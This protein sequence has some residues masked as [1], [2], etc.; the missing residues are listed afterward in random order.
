VNV[1]KA[2]FG[3]GRQGNVG[4]LQKD[5]KNLVVEEGECGNVVLKVLFGGGVA[6][7]VAADVGVKVG[8]VTE[9]NEK[10]AC[11]TGWVL[12]LFHVCAHVADEVLSLIALIKERE[13][14]FTGKLLKHCQQIL[15]L[16]D[17]VTASVKNY[18][19]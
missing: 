3:L 17:F 9:G 12:G 7:E 18:I 6:L 13:L 8:E 11:P 4:K 10:F 15:V 14:F 5:F 1:I 19:L 16:G 2:L